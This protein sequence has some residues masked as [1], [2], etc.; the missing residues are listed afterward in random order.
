MP[1]L[2]EI[3]QEEQERGTGAGGFPWAGRA[4]AGR[5][6]RQYLAPL[7]RCVHKSKVF[8]RAGPN[9]RLPFGAGREAVMA[10]PRETCAQGLR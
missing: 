5:P 3:K 9:F 1:D 6:A 10:G 2:G 7:P 8:G 4:I